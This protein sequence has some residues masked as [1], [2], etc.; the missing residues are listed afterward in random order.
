M[1]RM[2]AVEMAMA[3]GKSIVVSSLQTIFLPVMLTF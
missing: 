1:L 2:I 3:S